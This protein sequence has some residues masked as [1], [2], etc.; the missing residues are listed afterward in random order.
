M[1]AKVRIGSQIDPLIG[2]FTVTENTTEVATISASD[3]DGDTISFAVSGTDA[4]SFEISEDGVLTFLT[5]PDF[6]APAD[7]DGDNLYQV[8]IVVSDGADSGWVGLLEQVE[9]DEND[10]FQL[11]ASGFTARL[12]LSFTA[13]TLAAT[14]TLRS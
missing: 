13:R 4:Q 12:F 5:A 3:P 11:K 7:S 14:I 2:T 1:P 8:T 9:N 6:E 10:D